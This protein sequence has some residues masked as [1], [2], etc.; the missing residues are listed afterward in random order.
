MRIVSIRLE[1]WK[2]FRSVEVPL[3]Q[4]MFIAGPNA[5]GKS[6][7]LDAIRFLQDIAAESGGIQSAVRNRGGVSKVRCLAA[8]R[9]PDV[10]VEIALGDDAESPEWRYRI[11]F[12]QDNQRRPLVR[13]EIVHHRSK[14]LLNR[15]DPQDEADSER[16]TQTHLEQVTSNKDFRPIAD[17]LQ[18]V[19]YLHVVP[20]LVRHPERFDI[21]KTGGRDPFGSD[22]LEQVARTPEKTLRSRLK[23][24]N[25]ALR[26]AVPQ[27]QELR[28]QRDELGTPHLQGRYEHWRP[29][30]AWQTEEQL[31]D[32]TLRLMGLL[33]AV[34]D[35]TGPL[36]LEEPEL[37]LHSG[38]V[39]QIPQMLARITRRTKR[40]IMLS[41]H[42]SDMLA[43]T[44]IAPD[45]VLILLPDP[46]GT[47]VCLLKNDEEILALLESGQSIA[48]AVI[49]LTGPKRAHQLS[50][51]GDS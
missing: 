49:P 26:I 1:N 35:G 28:L 10:C 45:E 16:L 21:K 40:Q 23:R 20:Q 2:N 5:S 47:K 38:V 51:F 11:E 13:R 50:L 14:Q 30:G 43:D 24:I 44:G 25:E 41:T 27:L 32:G 22:F 7:F 19:R 34:M 4:R 46:N 15:P 6:N 12:H 33:W 31:S 39:R 29:Q 3:Q 17:F 9:Y 42:S 8:R 18:S 37:S 48:D 36:L